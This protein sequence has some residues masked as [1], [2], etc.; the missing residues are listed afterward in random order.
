MTSLLKL[1]S[2]NGKLSFYS[3]GIAISVMG[4]EFYATPP[5]GGLFLYNVMHHKLRVAQFLVGSLRLQ[6]F[7]CL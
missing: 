3:C 1:C 7:S 5:G 6:F 4:V 2:R